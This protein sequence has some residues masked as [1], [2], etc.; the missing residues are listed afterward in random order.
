MANGKMKKDGIVCEERQAKLLHCLSRKIKHYRKQ[1]FM[2]K[3]DFSQ[4]IGVLKEQARPLM[5][6]VGVYQGHRIMLA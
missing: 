3:G 2:M 6:N 1:E 5:K 4:Q